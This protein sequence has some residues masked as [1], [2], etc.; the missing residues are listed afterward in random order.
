MRFAVNTVFSNLGSVPLILSKLIQPERIGLGL[1][2]ADAAVGKFVY[3]RDAS[4]IPM[5]GRSAWARASPSAEF[6]YIIPKSGQAI[7]QP[8]VILIV[9]RPPKGVGS[10][11][12]LAP[13]KYWIRLEIE[14]WRESRRL[15]RQLAK[16]WESS[17]RLLLERMLSEPTLIQISDLVSAP[18][19]KGAPLL[20]SN[21][22]REMP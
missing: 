1:T 13:G 5:L 4:P 14:A 19:C 11:R 16:Q 15:G 6:F 12:P 17:G 18:E 3:R 8:D 20:M 22:K 10:T 2:Q 21:K 7:S 9:L